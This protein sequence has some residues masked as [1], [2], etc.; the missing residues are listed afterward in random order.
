MLFFFLDLLLCLQARFKKSDVF[1]LEE[2]ELTHM[3]TSLSK[4]DD[5][6]EDFKDSSDDEES[7][8]HFFF[9]YAFFFMFVFYVDSPSGVVVVVVTWQATWTPTRS[10][11]CT[12]AA[13][14]RTSRTRPTA[15]G[16]AS[17]RSCRS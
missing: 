8:N 10:T 1:N 17:A 12:L 6:G 15:S 7:G 16:R 13:S 3:G 2:E 9:F 11:R 4:M 5:F 14:S